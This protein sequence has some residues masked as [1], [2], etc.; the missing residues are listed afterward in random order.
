MSTLP[1]LPE[2]VASPDAWEAFAD[3]R[4]TLSVEVNVPRFRVRD[5][6]A[7]DKPLRVLGRDGIG[8]GRNIYV[9]DINRARDELGLEMWTS[10]DDSIRD[11]ARHAQNHREDQT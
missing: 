11:T 7:P 4:C 10:L 6:L 5:L 2:A 1:Q 3:L 8:A 9:P